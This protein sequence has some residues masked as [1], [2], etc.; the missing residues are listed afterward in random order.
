MAALLQ[1]WQEFRETGQSESE[2]TC[3]GTLDKWRVSLPENS[4]RYF[5]NTVAPFDRNP[6]SRDSLHAFALIQL[7][8]I[9][10]DSFSGQRRAR[11]YLRAN[12]N[13]VYG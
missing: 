3:I 5:A 12:I 13:R 6:L 4:L 10:T 2:S 8:A 11:F 9:R 7:E 1:L